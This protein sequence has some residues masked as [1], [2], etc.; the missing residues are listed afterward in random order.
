MRHY[1]FL[2]HRLYKRPA[3]FLEIGSI[4][5]KYRSWLSE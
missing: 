5:Y 3:V 1:Y 4:K 2:T